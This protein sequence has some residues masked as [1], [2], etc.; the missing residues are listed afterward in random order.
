MMVCLYV[1]YMLGWNKPDV[2]LNR[3]IFY[4]GSL[5]WN[6]LFESARTRGWYEP[7]AVIYCYLHCM[8]YFGKINKLCADK[9]GLSVFQVLIGLWEFEGGIV[10]THQQISDSI[11][12][13]IFFI[14][15]ILI[16][17]LWINVFPWKYIYENG[18]LFYIEN[19][20]FILKIGTLHMTWNN[21]SKL[22]NTT[23]VDTTGEAR[24]HSLIRRVF[25][26][27]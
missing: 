25:V 20:K 24:C 14:T 15:P 9:C 27:I 18:C 6:T 16:Y 21:V 26:K 3:P 7:F 23:R 17:G 19:E 11:F 5:G 4:T 12:T 1:I 10:H 22:S 13:L 2:G 8:W